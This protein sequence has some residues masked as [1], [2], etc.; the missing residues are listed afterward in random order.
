MT[1]LILLLILAVLLV[2]SSAVLGFLG[3]IF[4]FIAAVIALIYAKITW[5]ISSGDILQYAIFGLIGFVVL[6]FVAAYIA[7]YF[8]AYFSEEAKA[9]RTAGKQI[10]LTDPNSERSTSTY[11]SILSVTLVSFS[12]VGFCI[13]II[14]WLY[15]SGNAPLWLLSVLELN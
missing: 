11:P 13:Y 9:Q 14:V 8:I 2:G 6:V 1:V 5:G 7:D 15:R 12:I 10:L 4:G 3:I